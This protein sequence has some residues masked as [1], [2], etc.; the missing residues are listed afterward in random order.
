MLQNF[1]KIYNRENVV[2]TA[3][4]F[5]VHYPFPAVGGIMSI[6]TG[7]CWEILS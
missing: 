1:K 3:V 7:L 4:W 2:K 5:E 6:A